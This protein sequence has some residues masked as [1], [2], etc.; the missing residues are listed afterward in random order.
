MLRPVMIAAATAG[1]ALLA[2]GPAAPARPAAPTAHAAKTYR[3]AADPSGSLSFTR[4]RI[5]ASKGKVTL[6]LANRS[7]L[8]HGIAVGRKAG[9]TVS[10]G[11]TS[12][13]TLTLK[14]G[15]YTYYC[16]VA[17]HRSGGMSGRLVVR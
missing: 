16:P 11:G 2:A 3:L 4:T 1:A 8:S 17:G 13:V 9:R 6:S 15:T 5:T 10:T 7:P 14:A 12:R